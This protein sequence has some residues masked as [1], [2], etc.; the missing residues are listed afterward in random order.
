MSEKEKPPFLFL[1]LGG[2]VILILAIIVLISHTNLYI[3]ANW[4]FSTEYYLLMGILTF[5]GI[6]IPAIQIGINLLGFFYFKKWK[7]E[8]IKLPF[9]IGIITIGIS[10]LLILSGL[11]FGVYTIYRGIPNEDEFGFFLAEAI[12]LFIAAGVAG[13]NTFI[14]IKLIRKKY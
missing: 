10:A 5:F 4:D 9:L 1:I 7:F 3:F 2:A 6:I 14:G 13:F 8:S 11:F 12:L